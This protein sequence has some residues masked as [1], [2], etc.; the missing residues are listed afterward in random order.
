M[1]NSVAQ[2]E[3][4]FHRYPIWAPR[5]WG[6]MTV[7]GWWRLLRSNGFAIHA[8][9]MPWVLLI[10]AVTPFNNLAALL[11]L[12]LFDRRI[13]KTPLLEPPVFV[14][15]HWRSGTTYLQ[16]LLNLDP[17]H[18]APTTLQTYGANHFLIS[19]WFVTR[20]LSWMLPARRPMDDVEISWSSPQEDEWAMS[21]M[22]LPS[23]Y[24]KIA[25]PCNQPPAL[26]YLD[27]DQLKPAD[28]DRWSAALVYFFKAVTLKTGK[29][30]ILKSPHHTGRIHVLSRLFPDARFVHISRDPYTLLPS[31]VRMYRAFE[32]T[33]SLQ[34]PP[35][36]GLE[37]YVLATGER[38]Y[39]SYFRHRRELSANRLCEVTFEEL[40]RDTVG[41]MEKIYRQLELGDFSAA[42]PA[43]EECAGRRESYQKN[44]YLFPAEWKEEIENHWKD[45]F[46]YFGYPQQ[47]V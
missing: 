33:Q 14:I 44:R 8:S 32:D 3:R 31:T 35:R 24:Q 6:G 40:T 34:V 17:L 29:R 9:R 23:P 42:R 21:T 11:Q 7:S 26:D 22:G 43:V 46:N 20:F 4:K 13:R 10:T 18:A 2:N 47:T 5:Y 19:Q 12:V 15:G 38:V 37:R 1:V 30:L 25:F 27:M 45:Y 41:T 16:E 39:R 28:L 36:D